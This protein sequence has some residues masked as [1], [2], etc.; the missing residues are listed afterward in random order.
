MKSSNGNGTKKIRSPGGKPVRMTRARAAA[1]AAAAGNGCDTSMNEEEPTN[2]ETIVPGQS[3]DSNIEF[4]SLRSTA[5]RSSNSKK[6]SRVSTTR[7]RSSKLD[8]LGRAE[9][10]QRGEARWR[11][12]SSSNKKEY[13]STKSI[14]RQKKSNRGDSSV[15]SMDDYEVDNSRLNP[16]E[17]EVAVQHMKSSMDFFIQNAALVEEAMKAEKEKA[18]NMRKDYQVQQELYNKKAEELSEE[19][20]LVKEQAAEKGKKVAELTKENQD[21]KAQLKLKQTQK[22]SATA[23]A[24]ND[25][26]EKNN[27]IDDDDSSGDGK[28]LKSLKS[29]TKTTTT[30]TAKT[31]SHILEEVSTSIQSLSSFIEC[32]VCFETMVETHVSP[33]CQHRLCGNCFKESLRKCNN[34][35]PQCRVGIPTRRHLRPDGAF[36]ELI[37][38]VSTVFI[39]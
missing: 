8:F 4:P 1:A 36:D 12:S 19:L 32:P 23:A 14:K 10:I 25:D 11:S 27:G 28:I 35:C 17:M 13:A 20:V 6:W 29:S 31:S 2:P 26:I 18:E 30:T 9:N 34:E 3:L 22:T 33:E 15:C 37:D 24:L 5:D 39:V 38:A 16:M 7:R 21:L